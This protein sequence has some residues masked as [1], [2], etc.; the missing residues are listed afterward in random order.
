MKVA[1]LRHDG[2][3]LLPRICPDGFVGGTVESGRLHMRAA[4]IDIG[5]QGNKTGGEILVEQQPHAFE[6]SC[7]RSRSAA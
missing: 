7:W 6:T 5:E 3:T 1:V 4:G 2:E